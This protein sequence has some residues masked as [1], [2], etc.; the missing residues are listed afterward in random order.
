VN[1]IVVGSLVFMTIFYFIGQKS[2]FQ[3]KSEALLLNTLLKEIA[4]ILKF[5]PSVT[6]TWLPPG[7]RGGAPIMPRLSRTWRSKCVIMFPRTS[8]AMVNV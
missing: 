3:Q 4:A 6:V 5:G 7:F 2:M 1:S 8:S